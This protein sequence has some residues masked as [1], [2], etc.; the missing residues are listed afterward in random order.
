[1]PS[2]ACGA[3]PADS[4]QATTQALQPMQAVESN[5]IPTESAAAVRF[6]RAAAGSAAAALP[7]KSTLSRVRRAIS[8]L[9]GGVVLVALRFCRELARGHHAG[10]DGSSDDRPSKSDRDPARPAVLGEDGRVGI[11]RRGPGDRHRVEHRHAEGV[12]LLGAAGAGV[13]DADGPGAVHVAE[14]LE[15]AV[16]VG[17]R[18]LAAELVEAEALAMSL[19]AERLGE[20]AGVEVRP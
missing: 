18:S 16:G 15:R 4:R 6:V 19:V 13:A 11:G 2:L 10:A 14:V 9:L 3:S 20:T 17:D 12:V 8:R 7:A 5:S 1:M